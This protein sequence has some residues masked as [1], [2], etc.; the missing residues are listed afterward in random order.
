MDKSIKELVDEILAATN[1]G[2]DLCGHDMQMLGHAEKGYLNDKGEDALRGLHHKFVI[3]P[4]TFYIP[5]R[6]LDTIIAALRVYQG[7]LRDRYYEA[8]SFSAV[9][10][11]IAGDKGDPLNV[12]EVEE[13]ILHLNCGE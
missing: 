6:S 13:L 12:D 8:V 5:P 3:K 2:K 1:D 10:N 4:H 9:F 11:E 7:F